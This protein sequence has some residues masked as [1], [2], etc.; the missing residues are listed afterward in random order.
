MSSGERE[1]AVK[2]ANAGALRG[3]V[4]IIP[5]D[6]GVPQQQPDTFLCE[7]SSY[8][9]G[10]RRWS[11]PNPLRA[12]LA[13]TSFNEIVLSIPGNNALMNAF[14]SIPPRVEKNVYSLILEGPLS[15]IVVPMTSVEWF[16]KSA[17]LRNQGLPN[18]F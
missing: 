1:N 5:G 3:D 17:P 13:R 16:V 10:Y 11:I 18:E 2:N 15:G 7:E 14:L 8:L 12:H 9:H 4:V 6:C